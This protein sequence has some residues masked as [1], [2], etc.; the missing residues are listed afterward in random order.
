MHVVYGRGTKAVMRK[1]KVNCVLHRKYH[2]AAV[3]KRC[4]SEFSP[5]SRSVLLPKSTE[6]F[7]KGDFEH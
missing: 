7:L 3:I 6:A 4:A 5:I 2:R 1:R